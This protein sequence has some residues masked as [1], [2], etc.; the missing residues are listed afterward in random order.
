MQLCSRMVCFFVLGV[1][2]YLCQPLCYCARQDSSLCV[3]QLAYR[4]GGPAVRPADGLLSIVD[5]L[6]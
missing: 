4:D 3:M 6:T 5:R 2:G 1:G